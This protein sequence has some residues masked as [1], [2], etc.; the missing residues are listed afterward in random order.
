MFNITN[1]STK[2]TDYFFA[3]RDLWNVLKKKR[4]SKI[5]LSIVIFLSIIALFAPIIAPYDPNEQLLGKALLPPSLKHP[6]G[7]DHL[8]RDIF[9]RVVHGSR[10]SLTVGLLVIFIGLL[11]GV[12]LGLISGYYGGVVDTVIQRV[13]EF[14]IALPTL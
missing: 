8:G 13:I 14:L 9:S 10:I 2:L 11:F 1:L 7:T 12:P 3:L 6:M 4:S 5:G